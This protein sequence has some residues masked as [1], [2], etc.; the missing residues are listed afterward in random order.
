M[1]FP[2][3]SFT[4]HSLPMTKTGETVFLRI[5]PRVHILIFHNIKEEVSFFQNLSLGP[6]ISN[7][8]QQFSFHKSSRLQN[9]FQSLSVRQSRR[10]GLGI[11]RPDIRSANELLPVVI[12]NR[13]LFFRVRTPTKE[14]RGRRIN[15]PG[16]RLSRPARKN[17]I[18]PRFA[19]PRNRP[20]RCRGKK[21]P[22][23]KMLPSPPFFRVRGNGR[24]GGH[25]YDKFTA[26]TRVASV[27]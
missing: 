27:L 15:C 26:I 24:H 16:M 7:L 19:E 11:S 3:F 23:A 17:F 12:S 10:R 21:G 18:G 8:S 9:S 20:P 14:R 2:H 5:K 4:L 13:W 22:S 25:A 1:L 6:V